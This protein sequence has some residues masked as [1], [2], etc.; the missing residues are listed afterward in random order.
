MVLIKKILDN[1]RLSEIVIGD[2]SAKWKVQVNFTDS[3]LC[4]T[5]LPI[6]LKKNQN[7]L[8][9][10]FYVV[11]CVLQDLLSIAELL[12]DVKPKGI[13]SEDVTLLPEKKFH[14]NNKMTSCSICMCDYT[15][16]ERLKILP[17][18]HEFHGECIEKWIVVSILCCRVI[19]GSSM[20]LQI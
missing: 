16:N 4:S 19:I 17:C 3:S 15:L 14:P 6:H 10:C 8:I 5:C 11:A 20:F 1:L 12:G 9:C 18:F 13:S 2:S 7:V